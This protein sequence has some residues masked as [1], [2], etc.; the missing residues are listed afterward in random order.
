MTVIFYIEDL[1]LTDEKVSWVNNSIT[2]VEH[3]SAVDLEVDTETEDIR[4]I[5]CTPW[6]GKP[7]HRASHWFSEHASGMALIQTQVS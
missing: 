4:V 7:R 1:Q 2:L 6:T 5:L 3:S